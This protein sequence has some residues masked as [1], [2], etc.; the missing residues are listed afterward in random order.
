MKHGAG[1]L[2]SSW[3]QRERNGRLMTF[4]SVLVSINHW[5][6][7]TGTDLGVRKKKLAGEIRQPE[8]GKGG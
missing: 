7:K 5:T 4:D 8:T 3:C 2:R 1:K 6:E